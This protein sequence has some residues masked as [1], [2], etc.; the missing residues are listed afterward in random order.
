MEVKWIVLAGKKAEVKKGDSIVKVYAG[1]E[2]GIL[3]TSYRLPTES[4]WEYAA[5]L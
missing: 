4:E 2:K 3:L 5:L 1:V